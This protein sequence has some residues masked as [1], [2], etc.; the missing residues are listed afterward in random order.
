[1]H[2]RKQIMIGLTLASFVAV[3]AS[4]GSLMEEYSRAGKW[5]VAGFGQY[6][7]FPDDN[8]SAFGGGLSVGYNALDQLCINADL[9]ISC[10]D[11]DYGTWEATSYMGGL[12]VDY[13]ILA[14]RFTPFLTAGAGVLGWD[15]GGDVMFTGGLGAGLRWDATDNIHVKAAYRATWLT[16]SDVSGSAFGHG[17]TLAVGYKF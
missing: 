14:K 8:V 2:M 10:W 16:D 4:A 12:S 5:E 13:N 6:F 11:A 7:T 3:T 15:S 17:F 1:M 9:S